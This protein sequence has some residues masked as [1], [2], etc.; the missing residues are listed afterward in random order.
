[1]SLFEFTI[2]LAVL[3]LVAL[4]ASRAVQRHRDWQRAEA[5]EAEYRAYC[6][7]RDAGDPNPPRPST[8]EKR[9]P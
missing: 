7:A 3:F 8:W 1:M 4:E 9:F 2:G 5:Y 6:A